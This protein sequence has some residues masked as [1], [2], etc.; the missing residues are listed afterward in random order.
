MMRADAKK[1]SAKG[2]R[3]ADDAEITCAIQRTKDKWQMTK[4][5][6]L[7]IPLKSPLSLVLTLL[8]RPPMPRARASKQTTAAQAVM[9]H[10]FATRSPET[11]PEVNS[12]QKMCESLVP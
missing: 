2:T 7:K 3:T 4:D 8:T 1:S 10:R 12:F 9:K 6:P 5:Q 11:R